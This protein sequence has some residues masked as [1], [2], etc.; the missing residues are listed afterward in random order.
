MPLTMNHAMRPELRLIGLQIQTLRLLAEPLHRLEEEIEDELDQNPFLQRLDLPESRPDTGQADPF[1]SRGASA[2]RDTIESAD[3]PDTDFPSRDLRTPVSMEEREPLF[4]ENFC[5]LGP[6]LAD[7]LLEQLRHSARDESTR[8]T[9]EAIIW[10]L[11]DDGYLCAELAEIAA[12]ADTSLA[13]AQQA[14]ALVQTF[15]PTGVAA[16][17]LR[18]CLVLQLHADPSV[19]PIAVEIVER[20]CDALSRH[21]HALLA[22]VLRVPIDRV[23]AAAQRIRRLDPRPGRAFGPSDARPVIPDLT[24][25]KI[26]DEFVVVMNDQDLPVLGVARTDRRL[27]GQLSAEERRFVSERRQAA[28]WFMEAIEQR[29]RTLRRVTETVVRL[30]RDFFDH[31]PAHLRPLVLRQVAD[32]IAVHEATVSRAVSSKYIDTPHGVFALKY[33]FPPGVPSPT[34]SLVTIA[35]AK[36][37][38]QALIAAED[39]N[40]PLSDQALASA[41]R[42]RGVDVAR[43][44]VA[45]YRGE[46]SIPPCHQRKTVLRSPGPS[47]LVGAGLARGLL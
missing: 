39:G 19:D 4:L 26:G 2:E 15:D 41:L 28:R 3:Y 34:G 31:G 45:K 8:I 36:K 11:N 44:T 42:Q 1:E 14:L 30:Q 5:G 12:A 9:G 29:R 35:A 40:H 17:N 10:N 18:E 13:G 37:L 32:L 23:L 21:Q 16:R 20:H 25:T 38:L 47:L 33:F 24:V 46:L 22:R 7:H 43:R 6:S 27:R